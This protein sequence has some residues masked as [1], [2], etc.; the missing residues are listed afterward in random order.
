[1]FCGELR[2]LDLFTEQELRELVSI[3]VL[4]DDF[5]NFVGFW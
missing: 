3:E 5:T 2:H 4:I 1:M